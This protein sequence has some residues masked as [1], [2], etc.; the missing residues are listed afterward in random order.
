MWVHVAVPRARAGAWGAD[1]GAWAAAFVAMGHLLHAEKILSCWFV[2][3]LRKCGTKTRASR[4]SQFD[5]TTLGLTPPF[6]MD[7]P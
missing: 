4:G 2:N 6:R 3:P 5:L 7:T 1:Q